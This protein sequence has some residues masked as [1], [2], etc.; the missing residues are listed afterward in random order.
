MAGHLLVVGEALVEIMRPRRGLPLDVPGPFEGPFPSGAP[1]IAA[2]AAARSGADVTSLP[3]WAMIPSG[4]CSSAGSR[5][6]E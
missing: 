5:L 3:R 4:G 6:V 1:A 2:D